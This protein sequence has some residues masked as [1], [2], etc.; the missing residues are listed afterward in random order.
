MNIALELGVCKSTL[1]DWKKNKSGIKQ[2]RITQAVGI[3]T[4]KI[5]R[6]GEN[7]KVGEE[8]FSSTYMQWKRRCV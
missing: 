4:L 5:M 7:L 1:G 6:K 8:L 2:W 3:K